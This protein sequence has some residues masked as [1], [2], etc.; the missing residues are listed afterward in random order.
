MACISPPSP[1]QTEF[2]SAFN[3]LRPALRLCAA[4]NCA[5]ALSKKTLR[6][7]LCTLS[8]PSAA[9]PPADRTQ[10]GG[11]IRSI[12][13]KPNQHDGQPRPASRRWWRAG[14]HGGQCSRR[15]AGAPSLAGARAPAQGGRRRSRQA[16]RPAA[17]GRG[18][19]PVRGLLWGRRAP[20][21][22]GRKGRADKCVEAVVRRPPLDDRLVVRAFV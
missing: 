11:P 15:P 9:P 1:A 2:I 22:I 19:G 21:C 16:L 17:R 8:C 12:D 5:R 20:G 10:F 14:E 4:V 13:P 3:Q 18:K 6:L 7:Q